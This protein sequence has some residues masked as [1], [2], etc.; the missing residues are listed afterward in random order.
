MKPQWDDDSLSVI[1]PM[2]S[3]CICKIFLDDD[4]N[5]VQVFTMKKKVRSNQEDLEHYGLPPG[6]WSFMKLM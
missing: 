5:L 2:L 4:V 3:F 1:M 6:F